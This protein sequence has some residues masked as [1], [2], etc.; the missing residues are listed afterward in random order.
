MLKVLNDAANDFINDF[1]RRVIES[2]GG[3][4]RN[5]SLEIIQVNVGL[6][7]NQS[8][9]HCHVSSSPQRTEMMEWPI[10]ELIINAARETDCRLVDITG[11]APELNP[12]LRRF[13]EA[14]R[15]QGQCVQVR[16]NLTVLLE[17]GM[18]TMPEFFRDMRVRLAASLPCY[19]EEN[20]DKQ[21]GSGAYDKSMIAIKKLNAL[22]YGRDP[23]LTLDLVY[24]PLGPFLPP[25]QAALETDYHRELAARFGIVFTRLMTIANM[26]IGRFLTDLRQQGKDE[27]YRKLLNDAFNAQTIDRLMCRHQIEIDWDGR[28]Y[29]CDFN[30]A[31]KMGLDE[32]A[33]ANIRDFDVAKL[34]GRKIATGN[35][36]FGCTAGRGSSCGGALT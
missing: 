5:V 23:E 11:G 28:L 19:L 24:N 14:L 35:H 26:P 30:L 1:D 17:P 27:K 32:S 9:A 13:I 31:I 25:D 22:G 12:H 7:C 18:E 8:C 6:K 21:R 29:D 10:M 4:L 15:R 34:L 2:A 20:V 33:P 36:C 16:T 3:A